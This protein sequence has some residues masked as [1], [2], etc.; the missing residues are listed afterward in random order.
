MSNGFRSM[1]LKNRATAIK[2]VE[3]GN[4]QIETSRILTEKKKY[5]EAVFFFQQAS[6]NTTKAI[7]YFYLN[8]NPREVK[9]TAIEISKQ[10]ISGF[11]LEMEKFKDYPRKLKSDLD[12]NSGLLLDILSNFLTS[13]IDM[14]NSKAKDAIT[15]IENLESMSRDIHYMREVWLKTLYINDN[16]SKQVLDKALKFYTEYNSSDFDLIYN[17]A[18]LFVGFLPGASK[19]PQ[20]KMLIKYAR[21]MSYLLKSTVLAVDLFNFNYLSYMHQQPTRY[22]KSNLRDY[23]DNDVYTEKVELVKKLPG[24]NSQL[25]ELNKEVYRLIKEF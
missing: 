25:E 15:T 9:H 2:F 24:L 23:W 7:G 12:P 8:I 6:E 5:K 3:Y 21:E 13:P 10:S 22:P 17:S 1:Y 19:L 18:V 20:I 14:A 11:I 16:D 4:S